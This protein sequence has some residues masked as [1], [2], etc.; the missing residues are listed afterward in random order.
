M[1][2]ASN[3]K[4]TAT[5]ASKLAASAAKSFEENTERLKELAATVTE[6]NKANTL[7]AIENYEEAAKRFFE[8]QREIVGANQVEWVKE[9]SA[10]QLQFGEEVS[11]AWIKAARKLIK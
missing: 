5:D 1:A 7:A 2:N 3:A 9:T 10:T 8:A 6:S 11:N 4:T